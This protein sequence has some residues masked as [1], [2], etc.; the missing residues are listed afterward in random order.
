[1]AQELATLEHD[2]IKVLA[3]V[4]RPIEQIVPRL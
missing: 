2:D 3:K 1:L 4:T